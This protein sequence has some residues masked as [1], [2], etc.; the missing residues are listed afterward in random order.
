MYPGGD[1][2]RP[3][4]RVRPAGSG[5]GG[6]GTILRWYVPIGT[7]GDEIELDFH[8]V[9][10]VS[11]YGAKLLFFTGSKNF[12]I[13]MRGKAKGMGMALS[14]RGLFDRETKELITA[15]EREIF[16]KIGIPWVPPNKRD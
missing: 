8:F 3:G 15:D 14:D 11:M 13:M 12:N 6:T 1:E 5:G 7:E 2:A 10:D 9:H 16:E 4:D